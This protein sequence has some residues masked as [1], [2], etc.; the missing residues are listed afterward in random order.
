MRNP[1]VA[2]GVAEV[3]GQEEDTFDARLS[4]KL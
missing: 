2:D 3:D 1:Q 4:E